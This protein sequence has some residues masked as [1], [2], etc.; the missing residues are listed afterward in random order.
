MKPAILRM[1][2]GSDTYKMHELSSLN[3]C[4]DVES[5]LTATINLHNQPLI[6]DSLPSPTEFCI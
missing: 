1:Q 2:N 6:T 5:S 3:Q 4:D